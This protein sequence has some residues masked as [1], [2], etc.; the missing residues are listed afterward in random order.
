VVAA[1]VVRGAG[2]GGADPGG[3]RGDMIVIGHRGASSYRPEQR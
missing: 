1:A 2:Q 3:P